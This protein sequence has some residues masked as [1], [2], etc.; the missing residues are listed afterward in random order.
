[1]RFLPS[2]EKLRELPFKDFMA[3]C[4][5]IENPIEGFPQEHISLFVSLGSCQSTI[6]SFTATTRRA[7]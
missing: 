6:W 2:S 7:E 5:P 3:S 1:M 4:H